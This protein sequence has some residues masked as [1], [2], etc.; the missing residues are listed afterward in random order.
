MGISKNNQEIEDLLER[1]RQNIDQR[2]SRL[3][4]KMDGEIEFDD[5]DAETVRLRSEGEEI[6]KA[7]QVH[8][9]QAEYNRPKRGISG[10]FSKVLAPLP[11]GMKDTRINDEA[12]SVMKT[13]PSYR[14]AALGLLIAVIGT[15]VTLSVLFPQL[16]I[17]PLSLVLDTASVDATSQSNAIIVIVSIVVVIMAIAAIRS[18]RKTRR[19]IYRAA[20]DEEKW[21]RSGAENWTTRQRVVSCAA[22]GF[23]HVINLIYPLLTLVAL[24]VA[25]AVFMMAYLAEYRRSGDVYRATLASTKLHAQYNIYAF[26]LLGAMLVLYA[27][28]F[29]M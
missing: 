10:L 4:Q 9:D 3:E 13:L 5:A 19:F 2:I 17:S 6:A 25:G 27:I 16:V 8:I 22:F 20:H 1:S 29:F 26:G 14:F 23:C 7:L 24:S 18:W 21:F 15:V 28:T 12:E 11:I